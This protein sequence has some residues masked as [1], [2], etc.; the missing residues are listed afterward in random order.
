MTGEAR[1]GHDPDGATGAL[2]PDDD[3]E[4]D[5][6]LDE[7]EAAAGAAAAGAAADESLDERVNAVCHEL[8]DVSR[9]PEGDLDLLAV[10]G[11]PFG[12]VGAETLEVALDGQVATAALATPDT[13]PSARGAGWVAFTPTAPDRFALDRAEAWVRLAYRRAAGRSG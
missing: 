5:A 13:R 2:P 11:R 9:T 1:N 4:D 10:G 8:G 12:A 3:L 7:A 6:P